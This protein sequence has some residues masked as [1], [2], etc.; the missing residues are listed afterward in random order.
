VIRRF[1]AGILGAVSAFFFLTH[2]C[3]QNVPAAKRDPF[4][5]LIDEKGELR[6]SFARPENEGLALQINLM[7]ISKIN[8]AYYAIIDGEWL[9]AG[10]EA[11]GAVIERIEDGRVILTVEGKKIDLLLEKPQK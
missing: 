4:I 11:K 2:A 1:G 9:K 7:G 6:K 8:G 5:P 3:G 10:D